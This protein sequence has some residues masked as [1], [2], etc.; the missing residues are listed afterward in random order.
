MFYYVFAFSSDA[1][2]VFSAGAGAEGQVIA[3]AQRSLSGFVI[4]DESEVFGMIVPVAGENIK[5]HQAEGT[6]HLFLVTGEH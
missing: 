1:G 3:R 4:Q 6:D 5:D 2:C